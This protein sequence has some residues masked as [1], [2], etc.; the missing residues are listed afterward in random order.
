MGANPADRMGDLYVIKKGT[1]PTGLLLLDGN[2][3]T[4]RVAIKRRVRDWVRGKAVAPCGKK[5][6]S[7]SHD[8]EWYLISKL[9]T[10]HLTG[11]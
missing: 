7:E 11:K 5:P 4:S 9:V 6:T 1:S 2:R 10:N 8:R 3:I